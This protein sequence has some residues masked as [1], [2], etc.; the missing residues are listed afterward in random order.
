MEKPWEVDREIIR[1][2]REI[3]HTSLPA[4]SPS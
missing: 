4:V 1:F 3:G 2:L